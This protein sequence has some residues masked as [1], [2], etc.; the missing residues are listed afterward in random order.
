MEDHLRKSQQRARDEAS[1]GNRDR[2]SEPTGEA[3]SLKGKLT[4]KMGDK[5]ARSKP[6]AKSEPSYRPKTQQTTDIYQRFLSE[7]GTYLGCLLY[8]SPSPRDS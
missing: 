3:E 4:F 7:I 8:T 5:V 1:Q 6:P 2:Q